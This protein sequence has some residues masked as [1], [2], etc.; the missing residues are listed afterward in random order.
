MLGPLRRRG[1]VRD[2]LWRHWYELPPGVR[3]IVLFVAV[4]GLAPW[5]TVTSGDVRNYVVG[6]EQI[7]AGGSVY[8]PQMVSPFTGDVGP[9]YPYLPSFAI[10]L[11]IILLP[12]FVLVEVGLLPPAVF[13]AGARVVGNAPG[14]LALVGIPIVTYWLCSHAGRPEGP[15]DEHAVDAVPWGVLAVTLTPALWFQVLESGSDTFIALLAL[16]AVAAVVEDHWLL[17]GLLVG[18]ATFKFT[19]LPLAF[20]LALYAFDKGRTQLRDVAI[21]GVGSQLPNLAYFAVYVDDLLFVVEQRGAMSLISGETRAVAT[22]PFRTVG[23]EQWYVE[24]GF[25]VAF[26]VFVALGTAVALGRDDL[27]L[28]FAVA[29]LATSYFAPVGEVN[30]QVLVT[31]LLVGGAVNFSREW[32][33]Y[34]VGGLLAVELYRFLLRYQR[35]EYVS[36][37]FRWVTTGS[38]VLEFGTICIVLVGLL[39]LSEKDPFDA[40]AR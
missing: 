36:V 27:V 33:R 14:Y 6:A 1:A 17:A 20:V 2:W 7:L 26:F 37:P 8:A 3:R 24:T 21:G 28:G 38:R 9:K 30:E 15:D 16:L 35:L 31:L 22:A 19:A 39:V 13:D 5:L 10:M 23:L 4:A 18:T 11:S 34:L 25:V 32:V 29:Y 12:M 40:R